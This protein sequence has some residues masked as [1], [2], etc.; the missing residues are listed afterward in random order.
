MIEEHTKKLAAYCLSCPVPRCET[1]CPVHN[2]IRDYIKAV[3]EDDMARAR[4]IL[5]GVNPFPQLTCRLCDYARQCQGHCVRA[6]RSVPVQIH[7]LEMAISDSGFDETVSGSAN[8]HR[9]A[10][11]GAGPANLAAAKYLVRR[12]FQVEV[13]EALDEIGGAIF[14][15]IP[16]YRFDKSYLQEIYNDLARAGVK[17]HFGTMVGRDVSLEELL[18]EYDRILAGIGAQSENT[19]GLQGDGCK[20]GLS[21]LYDL[22]VLH[23]QEEYRTKY[24]HA[25]VWGGGNVAMDCARSLIRLMDDV[26]VIYRRSEKEM[27][28]NHDEIEDAKKEG[29][30]FAFLENIKSLS[31][32]EQGRVTGVHAVKM[33]LG[34]PDDSGRA[35]PIE[36]VGSDYEIVCDLVVPAIGQKV[37]FAPLDGLHT[38]ASHL[39]DHERVYVCGDAYLGPKTVAAAIHDGI[40]AA[41]EIETSF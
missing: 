19:Y 31:L 7:A 2:H 33:H 36:T 6:I 20:A 40:E 17:F 28:A 15:G 12:G 38:T 9:I 11:I 4:E 3:K 25:V 41:R 18:K 39:S 30:K 13:Y 10:M 16:S 37:D 23:L 26:T 14:S 29:V 5:Y 22:N 27:P 24:R 8:C 21:L 1:G 32:D 35:R 34:E